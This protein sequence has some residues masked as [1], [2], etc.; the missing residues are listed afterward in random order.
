MRLVSVDILL[1]WRGG[2]HQAG[3]AG[4]LAAAP[5]RPPGVAGRLLPLPG[6]LPGSSPKVTPTVTVWPCRAIVSVTC[7]SGRA[8]ARACVRDSVSGVGV[9]PNERIT[10]PDRIPAPSAG[11]PGVTA[12]TPAPAGSPSAPVTVATC[13]PSEARWELV[14]CPDAISC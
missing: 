2:P 6:Q 13:A 11:P 3:W 5:V 8:A 10:S 9:R 14:T 1:S 12:T 7:C 4:E